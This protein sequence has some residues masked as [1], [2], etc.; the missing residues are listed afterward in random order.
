[1]IP[2]QSSC[3]LPCYN[4]STAITFHPPS[5]VYYRSQR[6]FFSLTDETTQVRQIH[7]P[8]QYVAASASYGPKPEPLSATRLVASG[9]TKPVVAAANV[10]CQPH[11]SHRGAVFHPA[12]PFTQSYRALP[13]ASQPVNM[14]LHRPPDTPLWSVDRRLQLPSDRF[15]VSLHSP[16][17]FHC[18]LCI[19]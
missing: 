14:L 18:W 9:G 1:M 12:Q 5:A 13:T 10:A 4:Q 2:E 8:Q 7:K 11:C 6:A 3:T 17:L 16:P 19:C 15:A